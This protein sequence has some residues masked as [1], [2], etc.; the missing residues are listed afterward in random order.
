M[1]T[2]Y[3]ERVET[4]RLQLVEQ[5]QRHEVHMREQQ[6][7]FECRIS[8]YRRQA[9]EMEREIEDVRRAHQVIEIPPLNLIK[10][11]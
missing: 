7:L 11:C 2:D 3:E 9:E 1:R 4:L 10:V 8:E 5:Q 6:M